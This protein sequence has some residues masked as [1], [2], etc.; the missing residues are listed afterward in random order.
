M[1]SIDLGTGDPSSPSKNNKPLTLKSEKIN[2][3]EGFEGFLVSFP[4]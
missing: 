2:W 3:P 1:Q 4:L